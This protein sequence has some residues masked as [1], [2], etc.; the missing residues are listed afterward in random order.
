[1]LSEK[2]LEILKKT[3]GLYSV[4]NKM[5]FQDFG[6]AV[7]S[8]GIPYTDSQ[9]DDIINDIKL[10]GNKSID[11]PEFISLIGNTYNDVKVQQEIE[12]GFLLFDRKGTGQISVKELQFV[13]SN[14]GKKLNKKDVDMLLQEEDLMNR[15][16][17]SLQEFEKLL[18]NV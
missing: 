4:N 14:L 16:S 1:M 6:T 9:I 2:K 5:Q 8:L 7:R 3:F 13:F 11:L 12:E 15:E 18:L 17:I 10:I